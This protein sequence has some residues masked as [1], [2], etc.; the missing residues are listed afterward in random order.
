MSANVLNLTQGPADLYIGAFGAV[1]PLDGAVN[2]TPA[3]SAWTDMG[4]TTGGAELTI[5]QEYKEL[6]VDQVVDVPGRRLVKRDMSVKTQLAETT[7]ANLG[8][9]LN[10][11][12]VGAS[13][14]G[15]S[16]YYDPDD[17]SSATQPTYRSLILH[18][19]APGSGKRRMVI[20]R[21]VLSTDN[22]TLAY[23]KDGQSV[24][25]VVFS[26]HYV[27]SSIKPFHI[28]DAA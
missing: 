28:V 26:A 19:W 1:E 7:L 10:G 8:I 13:G 16:G 21:R 27:S 22:T 5:N 9:V 6:E 18:G 4:G 15:F 20:L 12:T 2:S 14:A 25:N 17:A 23:S 24:Y 11:G 3:T